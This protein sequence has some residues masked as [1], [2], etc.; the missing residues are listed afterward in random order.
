M[1]VDDNEL[2]AR[3]ANGDAAAFRTLLENSYSMIFRF[4]L[5]FCGSREDAEDIAQDVAMGLARKIR[6][7]RGDAKFSTWLYQVVVNQVRDHYRKQASRQKAHQS[8]GEVSALLLDEDQTRAEEVSW[9]YESLEEVGRELKETAVL[10]LAEGLN[11]AEAAEVLDIK[12]STVSWRMHEL[13]KKLKQMA[14]EEA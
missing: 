4:A 2:A 7:F 1:K 10:V 8:W 13:R 5:R 12:E 11:H 14:K 9:L 6:S 3:A